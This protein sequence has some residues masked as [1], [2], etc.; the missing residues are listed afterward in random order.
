MSNS[1]DEQ[2]TS[3]IAGRSDDHVEIY[4]T[5]S[6]HLKRLRADD[7]V[8]EVKGGEDWGQ[9]R[10]PAVMYDPLTGFKRQ[11]KPLTEEQKAASAANLAKA[12]ASRGKS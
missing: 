11:R 6:V 9:F 3:I 10:V 2:E 12:R 7:R 8:A 1:M 4:T 5:N